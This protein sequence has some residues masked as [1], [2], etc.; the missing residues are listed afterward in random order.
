MSDG[1]NDAA[2]PPVPAQEASKPGFFQKGWVKGLLIIFVLALLIVGGII[3]T[4]KDPTID[5][6]EIEWL[7]SSRAN[8]FRLSIYVDNPNIL[9]GTLTEITGDV[10]VGS[11]KLGPLS[12]EKEFEIDSSGTSFIEVVVT[13]THTP[14]GDYSDV[15][16]KGTAVVEVF[17]SG[18]DVPF[19]TQG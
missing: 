2:E 7:G 9:G 18:F 11:K 5:V 10:Y 16:A 6:A 4:L 14:V 15:W 12:I 13:V 1:T 19:N 17:G 8:E 3:A